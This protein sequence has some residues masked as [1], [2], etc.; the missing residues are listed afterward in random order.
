[1]KMSFPKQIKGRGY[2]FKVGKTFRKQNAGQWTSLCDF[3]RKNAA[4]SFGSN[5]KNFYAG[6]RF[7]SSA[8]YQSRIQP[9]VVKMTPFLADRSSSA[10]SK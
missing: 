2:Y 7:A 10:F 9:P 1:M 6:R 5:A 4:V 3:I 8:L